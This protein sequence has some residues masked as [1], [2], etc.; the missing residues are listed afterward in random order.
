MC[1]LLGRKTLHGGKTNENIEN[2]TR[3]PFVCS[4]RR[5]VP[6][7]LFSATACDCQHS[8]GCLR[9]QRIPGV[10]LFCDI[11]HVAGTTTWTEALENSS[12]K[13]TET[14]Q[15]NMGCPIIGRLLFDKQFWARYE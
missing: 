6:G 12:E 5:I 2:P 10:A 9:C 14:T 13:K 11:R 4:I 15:T 1:V 3:R 7:G 8:K